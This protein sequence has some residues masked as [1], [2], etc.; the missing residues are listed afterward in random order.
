MTRLSDSTI[1][2]PKRTPGGVDTWYDYYAGYS[3][4][5]VKDVLAALPKRRAALQ[6]LDPW[7][8]SGTTTAVAV[9]AGHH[10]VGVDLNPALVTIAK[11]RHLPTS[12]V[13]ES[14][15][16]LRAEIVS[17]AKALTSRAR[18]IASGNDQLEEWF[19]PT[20]VARLRAMERSL[21]KLLVD[22]DTPLAI[23]EPVSTSS[24]SPLA[25]FY[26][27]ALFTVTRQITATFRTSNPTWIRGAKSDEERLEVSWKTLETMFADAVDTLASRLAIAP[28]DSPAV[29]LVEGSAEQLRVDRLAD[30]VLTSPPYCT[31]IDYVVATRPELAILG[32]EAS[33][34]A[35]LRTK[36]LGSPLTKGV[37]LE[38]QEQWGDKAGAFLKNVYAHDSKA[39]QTYYYRYYLAYLNGLYASLDR[40]EKAT[41]KG[42]TICLV[43]QDSYFKEL[44]FD[45]PGIV[46][47]LG[48]A[49]G[50]AATR[51]DF[52]VQRTKA[53][54]HPGSR[55][56]RDSFNAIESLVVLE[57]RP[58]N[59]NRSK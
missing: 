16:P 24:L 22:E 26:Y 34:M 59:G 25:A 51:I 50:K 20:A 12:G 41:K 28:T 6:V 13:D 33:D 37:E 29:T 7:N 36:M 54:I 48:V 2:S 40:I 42:G 14:L 11:G 45:L 1:T 3:P 5:F 39:S 10:A 44:H 38:P 23:S 31:R 57:G 53:A 49:Q 47:E 35:A 58:S 19:T 18:H 21:S 15:Q 55:E 46:A 9:A 30:L 8:G 4:A 52:P 32:Y 27:C 17:L 56:Y 43:V